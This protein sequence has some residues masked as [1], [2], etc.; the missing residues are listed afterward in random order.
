MLVGST[1]PEAY[2]IEGVVG[3]M[4]FP[5]IGEI[6]SFPGGYPFLFPCGGDF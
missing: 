1:L 3:E 2:R 6:C 5:C 4:S